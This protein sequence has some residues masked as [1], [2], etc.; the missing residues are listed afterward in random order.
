[1]LTR[2]LDPRAVPRATSR[3]SRHRAAERH[4]SDRAGWLRA[5]VL[6]ANDG[7]V[8]TASLLVGV[9][10]ADGDRSALLVAG[11]AGL[12]AGALSMAA[13]EY[14]SVS[15]QRDAELA[16]LA[17]EG[18]ELAEFPE[19]ER[20][21]LAEIYRERGLSAELADRVAD[22]LSARPDRLAVHARDEL[23]IDVHELARPWQ[24]AF[25]SAISF[26]IGALLPVLV[27]AFASTTWR[28]PA[29]I[30]STVVGLFLLGVGGARL[31]GASRRRGA[32]R[33]VIGGTA[34]LTIALAI[35][36]LTG[37]AV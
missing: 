24:A 10:A 23:G 14:V 13:G 31:G 28:I 20:D 6:G 34:A 12:T 1:M 22:E 26:I 15:S 9:A 18:R 33:V 27:V 25:V 29:V 35:G 32:L 36:R 3:L 5:G 19:A 7:L 21:E 16:D 2:R 11:I 37:A 17:R 4:Y 8:S 30:A